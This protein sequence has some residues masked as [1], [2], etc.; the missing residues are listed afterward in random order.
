M[1]VICQEKKLRI[2]ELE[3]N[4]PEESYDIHTI[5]IHGSIQESDSPTS[6]ELSRDGKQ[7]LV[8]ISAHVNTPDCFHLMHIGNSRVG[9]CNQAI[10]AKVSGTKTK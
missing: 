8:N 7:I 5:L 6:L 10:S 4:K 2:Y 9:Y 3:G 1:V